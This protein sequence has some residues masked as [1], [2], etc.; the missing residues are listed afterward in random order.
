VIRIAITQVAFDT[1]AATLP[2]GSVGYENETNEKGERLI[3]LA[4]DVIAKLKA[5]RG[6]GQNY[7]DV[8]GVAAA[9]LLDA[10]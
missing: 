9:V 10:R 3:W 2:F 7:S 5:M 1:I 4:P 8:E 6:P